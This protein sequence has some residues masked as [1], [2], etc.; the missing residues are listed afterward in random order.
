M[1]Y[2]LNTAT[3]AA[4]VPEIRRDELTTLIEARGARL[5]WSRAYACPCRLNTET[6]QAALDCPRCFGTGYF[7][8]V[9]EPRVLTDETLT[10]VQKAHVL[11]AQGVLIRGLV[12]RI[13][14]HDE[15][16]TP[17][18]PWLTGELSCTVRHEN[19]LGFY[20]KITML[21]AQMPNNEVI[22]AQGDP[23]TLDG[24]IYGTASLK[25]RACAVNQIYTVSRKLEVGVDYQVTASGRVHWLSADVLGQRVSVH[26][27][28][29][30][31]YLVVDRPHALRASSVYRKLTRPLTSPTGDPQPLPIQAQL[32]L[33]LLYDRTG[34]G[35]GAT[36]RNTGDV[37]LADRRED[38]GLDLGEQDSLA[39]LCLPS[40]ASDF[41]QLPPLGA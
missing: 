25:Y 36:R 35:L 23:A 11:D 26:Y 17:L 20:D 16:G 12:Q 22:Y 13:A 40:E 3:K 15:R 34:H 9:P 7:Y 39:D 24:T 41:G 30:P 27:Q 6:E 8:D 1:V 21:D 10:P 18:G 33:E 4:K 19:K 38:Y 32:M 29:H 37:G 2:G 28:M 31:V 5:A 14:G